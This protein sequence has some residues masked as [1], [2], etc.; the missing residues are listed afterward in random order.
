M[1][2]SATIMAIAILTLGL[3]SAFSAERALAEGLTAAGI[4]TASKGNAAQAKEIFYKALAHDDSCPDALFELAKIVDKEGDATTAGDLYQH[5][6]LIYAQE[7]KPGSALKR[8]EAEKRVRT[9]NPAAAKL[10]AAFEDYAADLDKVVKRLP[11]SLTET[12]AVERINELQLP[13]IIMAEKLPK[14]YSVAQAA[15]EKKVA[16]AKANGDNPPPE[17]GPRRR[18]AM[19]NP[20]VAG[21]TAPEVEKELKSLGWATVTGTWVK[22]STGVY[23][24]TDAKLESPKTN[25]LIDFM[26]V[27]NGGEGTVKATV[28]TDTKNAAERGAGGGGGLGE[29]A[30]FENEMLGYGTF[31]R[32]K[33]Y[34]NFGFGERKLRRMGVGGGGAGTITPVGTFPI[35]ETF[36]KSRF[37]VKVEDNSIELSYNNVVTTRSS[38]PK[39]NHTGTF[40][41]DVNGTVTIEAPRCTGQ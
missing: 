23:E 27:K 12:S 19:E 41:L 35:N 7:A 33:D 1:K 2:N 13:T 16:A 26:I 34:R 17:G 25:G 14:F 3:S 37:T 31:Y 5:A 8:A 6:A 22:K 38:S 29:G 10:S 36:S 20:K 40:V 15:Q 24:A 32:G 11:D 30:G 4:A 28:R 39:L 21:T 9:L 18:R